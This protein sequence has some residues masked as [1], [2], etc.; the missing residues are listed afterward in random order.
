MKTNRYIARLLV[1]AVLGFSSCTGNFEELNSIKGA[2]TE[3]L[4]KFDSQE[5]INLFETVST[6]IYFNY[7]FASG[8][9]WTFQL[10]QSLHHDMFAGYFHDQVSSFNRHN[11]TYNINKNWSNAAWDYTYQYVFP[12]SN[13]IDIL[14]LR[15]GDDAK[16]HIAINK[17]LKVMLMHRISDTY[18]PIVYTKFGVS[19]ATNIVD[20]QKEAYEAFFTDLES[21][22]SDLQNYLANGGIQEGAANYN[23]LNTPDI[24][25]WIKFA[26][27]LRLRLAIRVANVDRAMASTEAQKSLD[28]S[29]KLFENANEI[30]QVSSSNYIN[31]QY[32][33]SRVW[34]ETF[35][36]ASLASFLN[37]YEDPRRDIW[38]DKSQV[39]GYDYIGIPQ[40]VNLADGDNPYGVAS[41]FKGYPNASS[42]AILMTA[43]EV[44]FLRAEAALR[45][46]GGNVQYCY[47]KGVR[48]SLEQ[49]GVAD[50]NYLISEKTPANYDIIPAIAGVKPMTAIST[51]TPKW[52]EGATNEVKLERIITQKWLAVFPESYEA[53]AEQRRTG[54]PKLFKVQT[55]NS[56]GVINTDIMIRRLPFSSNNAE[57][58]PNQHNQLIQALGGPDHGGTR[59][60][61][62]TG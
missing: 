15:D 10:T 28:M 36:H 37:G 59:L 25:T 18:G 53:W 42:P 39:D 23:F 31:P 12:V 61:W 51:I 7:N 13:R 24:D 48:T 58:D 29:D 60:W 54:Y 6:G 22:I 49:W 32:T 30:I 62:D 45:G 9:N 3:D 38:F 50:A 43:A 14:G 44:W 19:D 17:I 8:I 46:F 35:L 5:Y 21:A 2:L 56:G 55:N 26:N 52:D 1:G 47:E 33:L 4:K 16:H 20:T 11:S 57:K 34:A 41:A 40:G 27:S